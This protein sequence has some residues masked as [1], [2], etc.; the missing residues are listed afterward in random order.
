MMMT[1]YFP[2]P[3]RL[4]AGFEC[5]DSSTT[6]PPK[7]CSGAEAKTSEPFPPVAQQH[8]HARG[9]DLPD[10]DLV[11]LLF[12][13]SYLEPTSDHSHASL[14][15]YTLAKQVICSFGNVAKLAKLVFAS[16]ATPPCTSEN[17]VLTYRIAALLVRMLARLLQAV[18]QPLGLNATDLRRIPGFGR[19]HGQDSVQ[20]PLPQSDQ[21]S[22][23]AIGM[24][25][26]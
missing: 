13:T 10:C 24:C 15:K 1:H 14:Q 12:Q 20:P 23:K 22:S 2:L 21:P 3:P 11:R 6:L 8:G 7:N 17:K 25:H 19:R 5:C 16:R 26:H 4:S 18:S 9:V